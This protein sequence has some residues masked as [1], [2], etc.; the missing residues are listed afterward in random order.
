MAGPDPAIHV[1][2]T[3]ATKDVD[4]RVKPGHDEAGMLLQDEGRCVAAAAAHRELNFRPR[5]SMKPFK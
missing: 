1:F 2:L 5:C 3:A 4:A